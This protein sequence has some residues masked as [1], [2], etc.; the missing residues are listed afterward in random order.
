MIGANIRF[1]SSN[2]ANSTGP[3][4]SRM[5]QCHPGGTTEALVIFILGAMGMGANIALMGL[6]LSKRQLRRYFYYIYTY[7]FNIYFHEISIYK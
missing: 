2:I 3:N 5:F 6:I 1:G 4:G 7:P